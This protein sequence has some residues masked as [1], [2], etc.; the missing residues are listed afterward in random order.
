LPP[1]PNRALLCFFHVY[2]ELLVQAV[3]QAE[4]LMPIVQA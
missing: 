1:G 2:G 3:A 4:G